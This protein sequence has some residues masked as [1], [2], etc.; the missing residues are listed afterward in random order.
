MS[1]IKLFVITFLVL[2]LFPA[3]VLASD[4]KIKILQNAKSGHRTSDEIVFSN[5]GI[6]INSLALKNIDKK[7]IEQYK[8]YFSGFSA[9]STGPCEAG[10][11]L[12]ASNS[13]QPS[14]VIIACNKGPKFAE[15]M[16]HVHKIK[17]EGN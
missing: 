2:L 11:F 13:Q 7:K 4:L 6:R 14:K 8:T 12:F 9:P 3:I 10:Y 15:L 17:L 16:D 5:K 1:K